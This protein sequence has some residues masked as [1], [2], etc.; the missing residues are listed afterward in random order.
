MPTTTLSYRLDR[1]VFIRAV[2]ELVYR[3]LT[4][5]ERFAR[6][7][8]PGSTIEARPG[9]KVAIR[10]PN[11]VEAAGEVVE[12]APPRRIVF[13]YGF[14]S[15]HPIPP[16]SSRVTIELAPHAEGTHLRLTHEL[17]DEGA[18]NE[19][20]QGW[21]FQLSLFANVVADE[22]NRQAE[23]KVDAWLALWS[24]SDAAAR[25]RS[26]GA[27]ATKAVRFR[28]RYSTLD[29]ADDVLPH[30]AAAQRFMPGITMRREGAVRHCQGVA[31][32]EWRASGSDGAEKGRGSNVFTFGPT[33][34]IESVTGFWS[35][36]T[37]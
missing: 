31:I 25:A 23:Q 10:H 1:D 9:G 36:P 11:A 35:S 13:T 28:D 32:A 6:W 3:F 34:E 22:V 30:I 19:H 2:P 16:G 24:E 14:V 18:R 27:I 29:G 8:G 21:R 12:L 17:D 33:G 37:R 20:V 7:W 26:L 5:S 15:G 4:E